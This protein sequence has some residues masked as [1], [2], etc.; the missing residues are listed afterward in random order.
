MPD[1][2]LLVQVHLYLS[3]FRYDSYKRS[4]EGLTFVKHV[5]ILLALSTTTCSRVEFVS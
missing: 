1:D 4:T 2:T 5:L 3:I